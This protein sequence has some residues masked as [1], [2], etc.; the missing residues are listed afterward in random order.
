MD[1]SAVGSIND[2]NTLQSYVL[3]TSNQIKKIGELFNA[4][5]RESVSKAV[6][7]IVDEY[8]KE[9]TREDVIKLQSEN[10][11]DDFT[12][13]FNEGRFSALKEN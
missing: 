3:L 8:I 10:A 12:Q 11:W 9:H 5:D 6:Q 4:Y 2:P 7:T 1:I 13:K